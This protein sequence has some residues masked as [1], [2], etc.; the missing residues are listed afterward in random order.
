MGG[1]HEGALEFLFDG[2]SS[3]HDYYGAVG[4]TL[5]P[6]S[7]Q[8]FKIQEGYFSPQ[9]GLPTVVNVVLDLARTIFTGV[10]G[11]RSQ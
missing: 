1:F 8:E 4:I 10:P 9:Y 11:V 3:K 5:P 2:M 7:I 6:D